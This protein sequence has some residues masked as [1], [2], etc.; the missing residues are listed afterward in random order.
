MLIC[1]LACILTR[2]NHMLQDAGCL[3]GMEAPL[4][5]MNTGASLRGNA[6]ACYT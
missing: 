2:A 5:L 1:A 3:K 6:V 4:L